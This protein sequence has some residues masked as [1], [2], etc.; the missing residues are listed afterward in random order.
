M[1]K[2]IT[3]PAPTPGMRVRVTNEGTEDIT[4]VAPKSLAIMR[5]TM[6]HVP[7]HGIVDYLVGY[8]DDGGEFVSEW[9]E[10]A[11]IKQGL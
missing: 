10:K 5:T 9:I 6:L 7:D 3:L 8:F 2:T 1:S 4:V 11:L